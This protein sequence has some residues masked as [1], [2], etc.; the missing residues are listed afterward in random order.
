[1]NRKDL[2]SLSRV[3]LREARAL[4]GLGLND[5]AYYLAGYAVECALKACIAKRTLRYDFP[6]KKLVQDLYTHAPGGLVNKAGLATELKEHLAADPRFRSNWELA[7][8]WSAESR[9]NVHSKEEADL[10]VRAVGESRHGI[11]A[12]VKRYW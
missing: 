10:L 2:Q 6:D 7:G 11:L 8:L 5:G 1:V 4:L 3:R 12:W 9:Y